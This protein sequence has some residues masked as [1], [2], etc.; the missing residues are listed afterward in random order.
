MLLKISEDN[1]KRTR[2][3]CLHQHRNM[4][5][6]NMFAISLFASVVNFKTR[7][8][9]GSIMKCYEAGGI[10]KQA[11]ELNFCCM[12][13]WVIVLLKLFGNEG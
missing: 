3:L 2:V 13:L 4:F 11:T 10:T 1:L 7:F 8:M 6:V 5:R 12:I 9:P